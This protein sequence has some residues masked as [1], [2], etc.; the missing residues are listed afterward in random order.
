MSFIKFNRVILLSTAAL[1]LASAPVRAESD[2]S[3]A[4]ART[5]PDWLRSGTIYEIFP[6]DFSAAGNL[7]GVTAR[8]DAL[9]DLGVTILWVMPIH[10]IGEKGRKGDFG[11][12]YSIKDY[13]A[14]DPHYGTLDDFKK[15]V[16]GAHA[17]GMKVIMDIVANHTAWDS[18]M[19]T[20]KSFY[21]Q[22]ASGNVIPPVPS[23][24]DVAGLNYKGTELREY[25]IAM[26][27]YWVKETD[28]D[29]FRCDVAYMVPTDFWEQARA[30]I[31]K[32]K[33]DIM[34]LAEASKPELLVNAF[35]IDYSWPL[36]GTMNEVLIHDAPA[37]KI[38]Q[39]WEESRR[40]FP[41][42]ALHMRMSDDHDEARA[43]ARY[44]INGA[45]AA[46]A[47]MFTLDGV[48]LIYNGMEVGDATES[49]DPALFDKLTIFWSPKERPQ[50]RKI[51]HDLI[52]L[53]KQYAA[54][55]N[56]QVTWLGNSEDGK[57]VT[58]QRGDERD[59]F[60]VVVN[61]SSRPVNGTIKNLNAAEFK[62]VT[63][64]GVADAGA[65]DLPRFQLDG[66]GWRIWH[67][68]VPANT[69]AK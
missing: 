52:Q 11:S 2:V 58:F 57:V 4:T 63:I 24:T 14:V 15:L 53:R 18:V 64:S 43:V 65:G 60:V 66:Y 32:V 35:D 9:R 45:E 49:G 50:L 30:E 38:R 27:K 6:R 23:W 61:L 10:P 13:Y 54:L 28:V 40:Q 47:L 17:R 29:G 59:E 56:D 12:P 46:S 62:P 41:K 19:M 67:R 25:M 1:L 36:L 5:S 55:R 42:G 48:P 31:I 7:A 44:G 68:I 22:D 16:Q 69:A 33:P 34:M 20:N 37:T 8:L 51:Y 3:G 26:L 39:S 21:K